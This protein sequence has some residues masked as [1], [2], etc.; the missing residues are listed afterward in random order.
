MFSKR[1]TL[2]L[3]KRYLSTVSGSLSSKQKAV[4]I[5]GNQV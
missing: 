1:I 5:D 4:V 2:T 3:A